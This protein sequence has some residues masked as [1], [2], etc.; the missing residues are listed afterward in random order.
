[1]VFD[2]GVSI[3]HIRRALGG[4]SSDAISDETVLQAIDRAEVIVGDEATDG[5]ADTTK[6]VAVIDVAAY[7]SVTSSATSF[8]ERKQALDL[9]ADI[10]VEEWVG[11]LREDMED[12]LARVSDEEAAKLYTFGD[13]RRRSHSRTG[14]R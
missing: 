6:R 10:S 3:A 11:S 5:V 8:T 7:R 4:I 14:G 13:R 2:S 12:S 9:Q 1:M